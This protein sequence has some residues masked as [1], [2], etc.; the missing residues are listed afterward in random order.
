LAGEYTDPN[1]GLTTAFVPYQQVGNDQTNR[2]LTV[3]F[4]DDMVVANKGSALKSAFIER[5][6]VFSQVESIEN[7]MSIYGIT[8]STGASLYTIC[9]AS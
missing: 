2:M 8:S 6:P 5:E 3:R 7:R 4:S 1:T 9:G